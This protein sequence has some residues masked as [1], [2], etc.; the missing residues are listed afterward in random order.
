VA[1]LT[2]TV[3]IGILVSVG[4]VPSLLLDSALDS[5]NSD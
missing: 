1:D 4:V 3:P 2:D 5:R